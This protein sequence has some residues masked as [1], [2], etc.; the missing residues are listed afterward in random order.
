MITN[1]CNHLIE[2]KVFRFDSN[3]SESQEFCRKFGPKLK[4]FSSEKE[5]FDFNL[6]PNIES[7]DIFNVTAFLLRTNRVEEL[8]QLNSESVK[9]L[10]ITI[11]LNKEHLLPKLLQK[12]YK[13]THLRLV[14]K[15]IA[16]NKAFKDFPSNHK[17]LDLFINILD[18]QDFEG[19]CDSLKQIAIK[20]PKL[21]KIVFY[22]SVVLKNI[23][24]V[25]QF[26]QQL[27]AF[28]ALKRLDIGL[29]TETDLNN[30]EWFSG[31]EKL[32]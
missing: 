29:N 22:S 5:L 19:M 20:C 13:L 7:I 27:K 17:L 14:L 26:F 3:E 12:F 32:F 21:K 10:E 25:K 18:N 24:E 23:S 4:Y 11:D 1:N 15:A 8:L 30:T 28:P 9:M 31:S 2:F 16:L 6:F